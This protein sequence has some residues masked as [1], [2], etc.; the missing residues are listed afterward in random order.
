MPRWAGAMLDRSE[1]DATR[2][3]AVEDRK[4]DDM[5]GGGGGGEGAE[6]GGA[7]A[8]AFGY[9]GGDV[10][11]DVGGDDADG[12]RDP[13]EEDFGRSCNLI[14]PRELPAPPTPS[15]PSVPTSSPSHVRTSS[16]YH[17]TPLACILA[18]MKRQRDDEGHTDG[19]RVQSRAS[20]SS[21]RSINVDASPA[22]PRSP[23]H[24]AREGSSRA[25]PAATPAP[26]A[27]PSSN[28]VSVSRQT[29]YTSIYQMHPSLTVRVSFF[30]GVP[31]G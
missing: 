21:S 2:S 10:G 1:L 23:E 13:P 19:S 5:S 15:T 8:G 9:G 24:T 4:R 18:Q 20:S 14:A 29:D 30:C 11:G 6:E 3:D 16:S 25:P 22:P 17:G 12:R 26:A 28:K 27:G 31:S 7:A